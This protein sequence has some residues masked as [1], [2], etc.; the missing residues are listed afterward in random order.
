MEENRSRDGRHNHRE[1]EGKIDEGT[2]IEREKKANECG[3]TFLSLHL[4]EI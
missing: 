1:R 4:V 3:W 2:E